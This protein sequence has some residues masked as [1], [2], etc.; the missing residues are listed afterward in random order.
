MELSVLDAVNRAL[1][2]DEPPE[3][4]IVQLYYILKLLSLSAEA[5]AKA[6]EEALWDLAAEFYASQVA[7]EPSRKLL[8]ELQSLAAQH[9]AYLQVSVV[10]DWASIYMEEP[11]EGL[12]RGFVRPPSLLAGIFSKLLDSVPE[13]ASSLRLEIRAVMQL[14]SELGSDQAEP[15]VVEELLEKAERLARRRVPPIIV[16][17]QKPGSTHPGGGRRF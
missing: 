15:G 7:G 2:A 6:L 5:R 8:R 12:R 9:R 3:R 14:V 17:G 4:R 11:I 13:E 10:S 1:R 16:L